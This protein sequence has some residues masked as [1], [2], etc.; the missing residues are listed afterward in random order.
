MGGALCLCCVVVI[1]FVCCVLLCLMWF[2]CDVVFVCLG[3]CCV[4]G[5]CWLRAVFVVVEC[6]LLLSLR[7]C[8]VGVL[9]V[10]F[11]LC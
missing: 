7:C 4:V 9:C 2:N 10:L 11:D 8:C 3:L 6:S 5:V 1:V